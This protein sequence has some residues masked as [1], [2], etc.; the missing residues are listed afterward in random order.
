MRHLQPPTFV[1]RVPMP[2]IF[3]EYFR[4]SYHTQYRECVRLLSPISL[5][6]GAETTVFETALTD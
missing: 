5:R 6:A 4:L 3:P 2:R 1:A